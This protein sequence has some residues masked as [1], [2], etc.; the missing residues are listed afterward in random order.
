MV[1]FNGALGI[2]APESK[3]AVPPTHPP[4][5]YRLPSG[6]SQ[7]SVNALGDQAPFRFLMVITSPVLTGTGNSQ[8]PVGLIMPVKFWQPPA[9]GCGE[10]CPG[11]AGAIAEVSQPSTVTHSPHCS[12]CKMPLRI[13]IQQPIQSSISDPLGSLKAEQL[14]LPIKISTNWLASPIALS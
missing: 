2:G 1:P 4:A 8:L 9:A 14:P 13:L 10:P 3:P 7:M 12:T 11:C 5:K 6:Q